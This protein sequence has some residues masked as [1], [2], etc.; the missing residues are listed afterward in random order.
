VNQLQLITFL[1]DRL[2]ASGKTHE[3]HDI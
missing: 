3:M 1:T 2:G